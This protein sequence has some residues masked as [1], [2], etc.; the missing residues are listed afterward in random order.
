MVLTSTCRPSSGFTRDVWRFALAIRSF[1]QQPVEHLLAD[2]DIVAKIQGWRNVL[3]LFA[4]HC[5]K[6]GN[7]LF[8]EMFQLPSL[9]IFF[10]F[11]IPNLR[12]KFLE[13]C[14]ESSQFVRR[15]LRNGK[16]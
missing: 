16:L 15:E 6:I 3:Q 12:L 11:L 13:P 7:G 9:D 10:K 2:F 4:I 5:S 14:P 1:Y 8:G